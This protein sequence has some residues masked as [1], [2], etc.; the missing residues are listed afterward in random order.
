MDMWKKLLSPAD[1]D[2]TNTLNGFSVSDCSHSAGGEMVK[3]SRS[4]QVVG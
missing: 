1:Y 4:A 3:S 2:K